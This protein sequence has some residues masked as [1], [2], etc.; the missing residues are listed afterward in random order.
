[1]ITK[2]LVYVHY[3]YS[4]YENDFNVFIQAG[5]GGITIQPCWNADDADGF[6]DFICSNTIEEN[7]VKEIDLQ[8]IKDRD[9]NLPDFTSEFNN[10][11]LKILEKQKS[12]W[13][14]T[15]IEKIII[16]NFNNQFQLK[17]ITECDNIPDDINKTTGNTVSG[18]TGRHIPDKGY[19][20]NRVDGEAPLSELMLAIAKGGKVYE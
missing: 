15:E 18:V 4:E 16:K 14:K 20:T 9:D 3:D 11:K 1:M 6:V 10:K 17:T 13:T 8:V 19:N 12:T 7:G 5:D 2:V